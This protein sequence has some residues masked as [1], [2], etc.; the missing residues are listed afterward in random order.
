MAAPQ[1]AMVLPS[2]L[3]NDTIALSHKP[4][5]FIHYTVARSQEHDAQSVLIVFLNGLMTDKSS[6]LSSMA[7]IIRQRKG[8]A[9]GFPSMLAYDRYGQG[10]TEDRDPLDHGREKGH[11]HNV[12]D[13]A[14]DLHHLIGQIFG[15]G[16]KHRLLLVGNSIGCAIARIYGHEHPVAAFL[17]L[18]SVMAN[19]DFDVWPNPDADGFRESELSD[20]VTVDVL[21]QQRA[22]IM[23]IFNPAVINREGLSRR[24]LP[25]LLPYSDRPILG[26]EKARPWI[27][28]VGHD[29]DAF[30]EENLRVCILLQKPEG[31]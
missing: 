16:S 4:G 13:A 19:S 8:T 14:N 21:R 25:G 15:E 1:P 3:N 23:A 30:A 22:K 17:F 5:A 7:G 28:V 24:D 10:Q 29:F 6:W 27:S 20:D 12:A 11:G 9:A 26:T 18:D 2:E 31:S